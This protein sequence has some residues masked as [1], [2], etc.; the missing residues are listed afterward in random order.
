MGCGIGR[1]AVRINLAAVATALLMLAAPG[2]A[3]SRIPSVR[4]HHFHFRVGEPAAA[5]N[6]GAALLNG[7]RVLLRGL[8][9]GV[10]V[11]AEYAL[12]DRIDRS[13]APD[14]IRTARLSTEAVYTSA[15]AWLRAQGV[16]IEPD[17]DGARAK[18]SAIFASETL[19]H[20]A[21]TTPDTA[22]VVAALRAR[23][24]QP[25]RQT[26]ESA[27]YEAA[28]A[29]VVEI[30]RDIDAP[31][32]FW[33]PMHLDVRSPGAGICPI[34]GMA[35]EP[36]PPPRVGEYRMDVAVVAGRRGVGASRLRITVRDPA[37]GRP[38]PAFTA[39]HER[40]LHLFIVDRSLEYF[41]HVHPL[42][43][44]DG[45]FE[46]TQDLP[47]GEY[48]LIA[49]FLPRGGRAQLLQ[50]AIVTPGYQGPLFPPAP[51]LTPETSA[52]RVEGGVRVHLDAGVLKAGKEA[53]L[54]FTLSDLATGA[55]LSDLEPF[56]G[57]P[58]HLLIVNADLTEADHAHP[59][60][61]A[62]SG[63]SISFQPLMPAA[64]VYKL[65]FQFQR[66][67]VVI[68]AAFVVSVQ[69]P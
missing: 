30:V 51:A 8:G 4:F 53:V 66:R 57:A 48:V 67:G 27:F 14:A 50:R 13:E 28:D 45:V 65:W 16:D 64:G 37:H 42:P 11:G 21:F 46:L 31:D 60:E 23:G 25:F 61:P 58:G 40:L 38:V 5:M 22:A 12:F 49:D 39:I 7:S 47:P 56:L 35:L 59:E 15:R 9:V 29:G 10:R 24:H 2:R 52:D 36:I 20:V 26:G 6:H 41:R 32:A 69:A 54:R 34:C 19:D 43:A 68:T 44:G 1:R 62:T 33:C 17:A 55:P 3:D 63:P 18:F